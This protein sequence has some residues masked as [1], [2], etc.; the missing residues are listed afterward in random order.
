EKQKVIDF[1]LKIIKSKHLSKKGIEF[2]ILLEKYAKKFIYPTPFELHFSQTWQQKYKNNE[3]DYNAKLKD[4][5]LAAHI[6]VILNKGVTLY[7][8]PAEL[9]FDK[10]A[11]K[12]YKKS[13]MSD[14]EGIVENP[15]DNPV[16]EILNLCRILYF[17]KES[18]LSSKLEGAKWA[19][20][21]LPDKHKTIVKAALSVYTGKET[22]KFDKKKVL[23]FENF[24]IKRI[25]DA[26][27]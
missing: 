9:V 14:F 18:K 13:V 4:T 10:S 22:K 23:K 25:K 17:L 2:S 16:Y 24:M 26:D 7:G 6:T 11:A 20:G 15:A 8:K 5:D 3:V 21:F 1:S 27:K 19:I 12:F